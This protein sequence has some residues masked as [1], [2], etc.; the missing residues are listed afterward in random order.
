MTYAQAHLVDTEDEDFT[1][2]HCLIPVSARDAFDGLPFAPYDRPPRGV[3]V[4][5]NI[6]LHTA[7][8]IRA[9]FDVAADA[10]APRGIASTADKS[11][12]NCTYGQR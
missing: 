1:S 3:K 10:R 6:Y 5:Q 11:V 2:V 4:L 9:S 12:H 7:Q 8:L